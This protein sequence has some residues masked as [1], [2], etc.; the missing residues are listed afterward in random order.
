MDG[1]K[2]EV[3]MFLEDAGIKFRTE[4]SRT[5]WPS[6]LCR[7]L[8]SGVELRIVP[9]EISATCQEEALIQ[10]AELIRAVEDFCSSD[11][12][13]PLIVT[14]DRWERQKLM[15]RERIL[16]HLGS[17]IQIYARNC[18]VRRID[19]PLAASFLEQAHSYG[20]ASCKYRY[21]LFLVRHTGHCRLEG[22]TESIVPGTLV[23][24]AEF[25]GARR[26]KKENMT[27]SSYEW[28]RYASLP[29]LRIS[30]GMGKILRHFIEQ[31]H[32]DD[33]MSYADLEWSEGLV[34]EQL[35][36]IPE[37]SRQ[38]VLFK[39]DPK[40]WQREVCTGEQ[41]DDSLYIMNLGSRKY[42]LKLKDYR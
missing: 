41:N 39:V 36:F 13:Y 30:G 14:R 12:A 37:D 29:W 16:A 1:F 11:G 32:P 2:D 26:W 40:G 38:P 22:A 24:V 20:D 28:T 35:G 7:H 15:M 6:V 9:V 21:G 17:Y 31:V 10:Q 4:G 3:T 27:V 19:K 34:Y 5:G 42:R 23:A 25:S 33:I 18:Q 8:R